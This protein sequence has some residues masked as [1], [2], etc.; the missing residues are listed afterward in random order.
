MINIKK[1]VT[2]IIPSDII[3]STL[4]ESGAIKSLQ[5]QF[6]VT[7]LESP[8]NSKQFKGVRSTVQLTSKFRLLN[9]YLGHH[10]WY[11]SLYSYL[12]LRRMPFNQSFKVMQQRL[13][14]RKIY[15]IASSPTFAWLVKWLD[16]EVIFP[17]DKAI[18]QYL[19]HTQ[20]QLVIFPG[21]AMDTY[22]HIVARTAKNNNIPTAMIITHW[23]F[24]SKKST[25]RFSPNKIYVWGEDMRQMALVD[26]TL[27]ADLVKVIGSPNL[28]RYRLGAAYD[29][30]LARSSFGISSS[31]K[32]I[33]F[34]GTSVPY[35]EVAVLQ[36][37]NYALEKAGNNDVTIIYRPHP[38]GWKRESAA[39][40]DPCDMQFVII[41]QPEY[42][43]SASPEHYLKLLSA[44]DGIVSPFS[45]MILEGALCGKPSLCISFS[46]E[47][48]E[49]DF[50]ITNTTDH[51]QN[52]KN[53]S[54][55]TVCDKSENLEDLFN[56][57]LG[58]LGHVNENDD[59]KLGVK[60]I[61]YYDEDSYANRLLRRV[62]EDFSL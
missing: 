46:D 9:K 54:W 14:W 3:I 61:V 50:S 18:E 15:W 22:S 32:V 33:L 40:M 31:S 57:F 48:N 19:Q 60:N 7:Y 12:R 55:S 44:I 27:D 51:L 34:A 41:D 53:N 11:I 43:T 36:R 8:G 35:D 28:D 42:R 6:D 16:E 2:I 20:P 30:Q 49:F 21:S 29:Q 17:K 23:D 39:T 45:T 5:E 56:A 4:V 62:V 13:I 1:R 58:T 25:L 10:F 37:L 47:I 38:R 59:I 24:F 26:S 52:V